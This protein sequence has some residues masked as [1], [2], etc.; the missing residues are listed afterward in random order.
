M[1][2]GD[3]SFRERSEICKSRNDIKLRC[4]ECKF[5]KICNYWGSPA[6]LLQEWLDEEYK[7]E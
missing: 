2:I 7:K 6:E 1:K 3:V 4:K 5:S